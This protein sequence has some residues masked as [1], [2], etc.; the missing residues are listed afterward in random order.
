M[1]TNIP[2]IDDIRTSFPQ[3]T[4]TPIEGE[5]TYES[6]KLLHNQLKS[7]AASVPSTLGGGNHGHLGLVLQA[8]LYTTVLGQQFVEP[9]NP[10]ITPNIPAGSTN[11]QI[12][13]LTRQFNAETKV[14]LEYKRTDAA[15]KQQLLEAI[16]EVYVESLRNIHTGYTTVTTLQLLTHLYTNYGQI[17]AM[18]LDENEKRMKAKYDPNDPID[19]LFKQIE[20]AEE[21]AITGNAP[22]TARQ[23]VNTA[24]LLIFATGVYEDECKAWKRRPLAQQ[25]W[26][27]FKTDFMAAYKNRRELQKLQQQGSPSQLFG[28]NATTEDQSKDDS[29]TYTDPSTITDIFSDT[30]DK[31][32]AIANATIE[33]G[34][35]VAHLAQENITLKK[36]VSEMQEILNKMQQTILTN[37]NSTSSSKNSQ[38]KSKPKRRTVRGFDAKSKHYCWSHGL[39]R[40]PFH[41]SSTCRDPEP[42][43]VKTATF[44]NKKGG[45]TYK[46][47]L[48]NAAEQ[49]AEE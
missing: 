48:A 14:Y 45:S 6:I 4:I 19:K 15:L 47:H 39:T 42:G 3:P 5:P 1:S 24:F 43:H 10:G 13:V 12:G 32:T 41:T 35:Q 26:A 49:T 23:I 20:L 27:N 31:I 2:S 36:Q 34:T 44:A 16:G 46:C 29:F 17:S 9:P 33:S 8:T 38:D 25:T 30:S 18:D 28:A 37:D 40:T 7:N 11:A 22:F 21:L